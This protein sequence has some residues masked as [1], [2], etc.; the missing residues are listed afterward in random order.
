MFNSLV[1]GL[2]DA[3]SCNKQ[4]GNVNNDCEEQII[5]NNERKMLKRIYDSQ[6][7]FFLKK[8]QN[9]GFLLFTRHCSYDSIKS[10]EWS[11]VTVKSP[12]TIVSFFYKPLWIK[13]SA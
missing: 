10:K 13:A 6:L 11:Q 3:I 8:K 12:R 9:I 2:F 5:K 4:K 1:F 7:M